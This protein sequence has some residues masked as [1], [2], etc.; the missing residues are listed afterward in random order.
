MQDVLCRFWALLIFS[1]YFSSSF[2][3][4]FGPIS[5]VL[6]SLS[7][8]YLNPLRS[9]FWSIIVWITLVK[10]TCCVFYASKNMRSCILSIASAFY[11]F[12]VHHWGTSCST[13]R[14]TR[15]LRSWLKARSLFFLAD[16][17][18]VLILFDSTVHM[19]TI[20]TAAA[21]GSSYKD[22]FFK[23]RIFEIK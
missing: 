1:M 4:W 15:F 16:T 20:I 11:L 8:T 7:S 3:C 2:V 22:M 14:K 13:T 10:N 12:L 21:S 18:Q 19:D 6:S 23:F 5:R 17:K 9:Q